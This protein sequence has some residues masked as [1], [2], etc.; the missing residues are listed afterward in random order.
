MVQMFHVHVHVHVPCPCPC[1]CAH[2]HVHATLCDPMRPR[3]RTQA[4]LN[5]SGAPVGGL[6]VTPLLLPTPTC[7]TGRPPSSR[8]KRA[9]HKL[10]GG[11]VRRG[12]FSP[13][14]SCPPSLPPSR[15]P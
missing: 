13:V 10:D 6:G 14:Q 12:P 2:V 1:L 8:L 7:A 15:L 5:V 11:A 4:L 9:P 3:A